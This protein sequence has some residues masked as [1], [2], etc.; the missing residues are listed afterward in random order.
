M[1]IYTADQ[2]QRYEFKEEM[3]S[4][5]KFPN[6]LQLRNSRAKALRKEGWYVASS[7][8]DFTDLARCRVYWLRGVKERG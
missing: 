2:L 6:A 1:T 5:D 7:T 3:F 8:T 4:D